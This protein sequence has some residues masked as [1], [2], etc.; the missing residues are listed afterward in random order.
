MSIDIVKSI[1]GLINEALKVCE[2][3]SI[4]IGES[5]K[6]YNYYPRLNIKNGITSK[7]T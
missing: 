4:E 7:Y 3:Q 2:L 5:Y 6:I 1:C